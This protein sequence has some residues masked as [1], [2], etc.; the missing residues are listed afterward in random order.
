MGPATLSAGHEQ[1]ADFAQRGRR[2]KAYYEHMRALASLA[3]ARA[4][5]GL[6]GVQRMGNSLG[7]LAT[8]WCWTPASTAMPVCGPASAVRHG[9]HANPH[10]NDP[11][12]S[13]LGHAGAWLEGALAQAA[14]A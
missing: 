1:L 2:V 6:T 5:G 11:A 7:A 13:L 10:W 9:A 8:S 4:A 12:R 14:G 3:R